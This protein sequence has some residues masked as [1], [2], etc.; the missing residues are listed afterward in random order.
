[1]VLQP[2]YEFWTN[3]GGPWVVRGG[4]G[5]YVPLNVSQGPAGTAYT[6]DL[7]I[8]A[9]S[10]PTTCRLATWSSMPQPTGK[11]RLDGT[12]RTG[13]YFGVGPGT[14]FHIAKNF[15]FL[16]YWEFPLIGPHPYHL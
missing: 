5:F 12:S 11:R 14:R 9:T 4:S 6:G 15:I 1:M 3:P 16:H 10:L 2:K 13:T 8:A 7:A